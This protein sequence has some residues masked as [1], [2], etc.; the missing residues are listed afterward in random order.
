VRESRCIYSGVR[1]IWTDRDMGK[2]AKNGPSFVPGKNGSGNLTPETLMSSIERFCEANLK[3][4]MRGAT[5]KP[6][7]W[8]N[9]QV[10]AARRKCIYSRRKYTRERSPSRRD[11]LKNELKTAQ[12]ALKKAIMVSK[13][14][15]LKE[16]CEHIDRDPGAWDTKLLLRN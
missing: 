7:Y 1:W 2:F 10:E 9:S 6:A 13:R 14:N 15:K 3:P 4:A 5:R 8:W 11:R 16:L 12:K